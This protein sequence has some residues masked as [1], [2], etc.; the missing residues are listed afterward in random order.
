MWIVVLDKSYGLRW[1]SHDVRRADRT[2]TDQ[3]NGTLA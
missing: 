2:H 1:Q 3:T